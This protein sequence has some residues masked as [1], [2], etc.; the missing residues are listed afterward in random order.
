MPGIDSDSARTAHPLIFDA[1]AARG[2]PVTYH[3]GQQGRYDHDSVLAGYGAERVGRWLKAR[4]AFLSPEGRRMFS[5]D[6]LDA[7]G[8]ST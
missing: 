7:C 1:L 8:L 6:L 3:W 2:I 4:R 5:N